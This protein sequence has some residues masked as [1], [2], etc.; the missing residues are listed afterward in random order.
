M[1]KPVACKFQS[2]QNEQ[3]GHSPPLLYFDGKVV[4]NVHQH[5]H[6]GLIF[7]TRLSWKDHVSEIME[8]LWRNYGKCI[9]VA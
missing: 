6:L 1:G 5:K 4:E 7:N 8:K 2:R 9:K 3:E